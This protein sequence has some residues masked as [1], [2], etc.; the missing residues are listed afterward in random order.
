MLAVTQLVGFGAARSG[1][2]ATDFSEYSTGSAPGDWVEQYNTGDF[3]TT[4][5][6]VVGSISG[7]VLRYTKTAGSR[8][9]FSWSR[10]P[11]CKDAEVL[12]RFRAIESWSAGQ[13]F[14]AAWHRGTGSAGSETGYRNVVSGDTAGTQYSTLSSLYNSGTLTNIVSAAY[15]PSPNYTINT[16]AYVRSQAIGSVIQSK[17]WLS[18]SAEPDWLTSTTDSTLTAA[19]WTGLAN[20]STNPNVEIDYFAVSIYGATIPLPI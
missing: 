3:S 7:K 14:I 5:A 15:G 2:F 12:I 1:I 4:I 16:W 10:V 18:G 20:A 19:G 11:L 9:G 6:A 8:Q 13:N 17:I